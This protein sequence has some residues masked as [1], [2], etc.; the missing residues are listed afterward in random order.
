M[1][2]GGEEKL[3]V[4]RAFTVITAVLPLDTV[5][6]QLFEFLMDVMVTVVEPLLLNEEV[7]KVPLPGAPEVKLIVAV[8]PV[9]ELGDDKL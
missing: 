7:V 4:G 5:C 8:F 2:P 6:E 9:A 1:A 3:G